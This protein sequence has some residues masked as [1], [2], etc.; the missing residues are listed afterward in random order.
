M[1]SDDKEEADKKSNEKQAEKTKNYFSVKASGF[2]L[3]AAVWYYD[4]RK[5]TV[6]HILSTKRFNDEMFML[7][8][9]VNNKFLTKKNITQN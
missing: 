2:N 9:F 8:S 7:S 1:V 6:I 5:K 4:Q 3:A